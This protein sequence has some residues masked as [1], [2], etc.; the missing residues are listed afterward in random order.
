MIHLKGLIPTEFK[1][2]NTLQNRDLYDKPK[3]ITLNNTIENV[4]L[5]NINTIDEK[6][7]KGVILPLKFQLRKYFESPGIFNSFIEHY[8]FLNEQIDYTNFINSQLWKNKLLL[9]NVDSSIIIP[10]F[11]YFDD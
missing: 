3:I 5:H 10:Y 9:L 7:T 2:L 4:V 1:F 8:N 6:K 11:L